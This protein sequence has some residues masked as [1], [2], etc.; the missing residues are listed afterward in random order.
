MFLLIKLRLLGKSVARRMLEIL[1]THK[2]NNSQ[3]VII[4][5]CCFLACLLL[6]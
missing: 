1:Q 4:S 3:K 2:L 5:E 6:C